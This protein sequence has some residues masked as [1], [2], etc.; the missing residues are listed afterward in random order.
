MKELSFCG[1]K[2]KSEIGHSVASLRTSFTSCWFERLKKNVEKC[3][4]ES[5]AYE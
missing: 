3:K 5:S 4:I 2:E 1:I